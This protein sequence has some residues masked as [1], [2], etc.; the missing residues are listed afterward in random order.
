[1]KL[2]SVLAFML[3]FCLTLSF[4]CVASAEDKT[5]VTIWHTF[6]GDQEA[7]LTEIAN[8]FNASQDEIEVLVQSQ[9]YSGFLDNVMSAVVNGVGPS[10]IFNYASTAA[11]YV[12]DGLVIDF[13]KYI[14]DEEIGIPNFDESIKP[15][16]L[17]EMTGYS[18]GGMYVV[19]AVTTGPILFYNKTMLEE[20][21]L[22]VPTTWA[23]MEAVS[24][25]VYEA[26]NIPGF[27]V[28]SLTDTMHALIF[29]GGSQY[30]DKESKTALF[31][32]DKFLA[33]LTTFSDNV[34]AGY[35]ALRPTGDYW[36]NDFNAQMCAMYIGSCAG[37]P[38]ITPDGFEYDVAPMPQ[39][40]TPWYPA[41]N[42]GLIGFTKDEEADKAT[43]EFV[44]YFIQ[45][46]NNIKWCKA[47][48]A[49]SPYYATEELDEYKTFVDA[50]PALK[51]VQ[52]GT[53]VAGFLPSIPGAY[54]VRQEL[55]QAA[56][57]AST[58]MTA[59]DALAQAIEASNEALQEG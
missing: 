37:V 2:R 45:T 23:E 3:V 4:C 19:S 16:I 58:D 56:V 44:K 38:Y 34:R 51:A 52:E 42:R 9:P 35:Y 1:M 36:S 30:I 11:D 20:L 49:L 40:G 26:K 54:A 24:K 10:L 48:L 15:G 7:C 13:S 18:D 59:A 17:A 47:M 46:E 12:E 27:A 25:A 5:Q 29:Q 57:L 41:W 8:D 33:Q 32:D 53:E 31:G 14:Y 28:D 21:N 22:S 50:N 39:E 55:E 43:Y 6:T